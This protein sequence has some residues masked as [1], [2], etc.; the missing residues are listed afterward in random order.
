MWPQNLADH[1]AAS[2]GTLVETINVHHCHFFTDCLALNL[3]RKGV[4]YLL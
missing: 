2:L 1:E 4:E 3:F